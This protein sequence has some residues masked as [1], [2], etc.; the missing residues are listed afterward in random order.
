M[1]RVHVFGRAL[2]PSFFFRAIREEIVLRRVERRRWVGRVFANEDFV[3][4]FAS[5]FRP[6]VATQEVKL[7]QAAPWGPHP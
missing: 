6:L 2:A 5:K 1:F 4:G 3:V 7:L